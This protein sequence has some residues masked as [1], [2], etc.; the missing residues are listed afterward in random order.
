MCIINQN[1]FIITGGPGSGKT[2]VLRELAKRGY[3]YSPEVARQI[4]QEQIKTGGN[5]LPWGDTTLYTELMLR[6][7]IQ[8]FL[9]HTPASK[10]TFAD[11][12][13]P[14]TLSYARLISLTEEGHIQ[15]ACDQYRYSSNIFIAPPWREI[16]ETDNERKQDFAE[17]VRTYELLAHVYKECGYELMELPCISPADRADFIL[18][19][20]QGSGTCSILPS[21]NT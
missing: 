5:A 8:S 16:Y 12:G 18:N 20:V 6:R 19:H 11:R 9:E 21:R 2:T 14:D 1:L 17:A 15:D 4:I 3:E 7:S 10:L 13:V